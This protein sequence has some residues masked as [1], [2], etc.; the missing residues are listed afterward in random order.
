MS[1]ISRPTEINEALYEVNSFD[2]L[3][4][5]I[6]EYLERRMQG[7]EQ[8]VRTLNSEVSKRLDTTKNVSDWNDNDRIFHKK[9]FLSGMAG[10][11][12]YDGN[13][14]RQQKIANLFGLEQG[15]KLSDFFAESS[16]GDLKTIAEKLGHKFGEN[17]ENK[18]YDKEGLKKLVEGLALAREKLLSLK[19]VGEDL[20]KTFTDAFSSSI[21]NGFNQT[22]TQIGVSFRELIDSSENFYEMS[23]NAESIWQDAGEKISKTWQNMT[24]Q[25]LDAI[26]PAMTQAGLQ[27]IIN[28]PDNWAA[29]LGMIAAGGVTQIMSGFL[30]QEQ[31][32]KNEQ[33]RKRLQDLRSLLADIIEQAKIDASY[34][35]KNVLHQKALSEANHI[36]VNDAIIAPNGNVISTSPEDYLIATKTPGNYANLSGDPKVTFNLI[37]QSSGIQ[38]KSIK[39]TKKS[40]GTFNIEALVVSKV[41]E[42]VANGDLDGALAVREQRMNGTSYAY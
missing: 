3:I 1:D 40:D 25:M 4:N 30:N 41:A 20:G 32:D 17:G 13:N 14:F 27:M 35:E 18:E 42:A 34:Y 22:M 16:K 2:K 5:T 26:G 8:G 28:D 24:Q 36:S 33:E 15:K 11:D 37:D 12:I 9:N 31:A 19:K 39:Q 21:L 10:F 38:V 6:V 29:G 23:Y 7:V